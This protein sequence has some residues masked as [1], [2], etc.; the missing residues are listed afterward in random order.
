VKQL[1]QI[2]SVGLLL[3][4]VAAIAQ[5]WGYF[6]SVW[7]GA[8]ATPVTAGEDGEAEALGTVREALALMAHFYSSGADPRFAERMPVAPDL[9][10]EFRGDIEYL[11][12]N[13]RFQDSRLQK[14]ELRSA[15]PAGKDGLE[16]RTREFWIHRTFWSDGR[17]ESDPPRSVILYPSY[18][19]MRESTGW[20]ILGREFDRPVAE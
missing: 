17:G 20:R 9:L 3:F 6:S 2:V 13:N 8:T 4:V 15:V 12:R 18:Q 16:L 1:L 5:E 19:L 11:S 7:F 14:L 10:D